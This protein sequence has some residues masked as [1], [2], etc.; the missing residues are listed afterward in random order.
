MRILL[1]TSEWPVG[2]ETYAGNFVKRQAK[3]LRR[4]GLDVE[5]FHFHGGKNPLNYLQAWAR[6]RPLLDRRRFDLVHAHFGQSGLLALPR[7]LPLVV[8]FHGTDVLGATSSVSDSHLRYEK[9]LSRVSRFVAARADALIV[10]GDHMRPYLPNTK[11]ISVI[12][13]GIDLEIFR[14]LPKDVARAHLGLP[15]D[16]HLVLFVGDPMS[17]IKHGTL[18]QRAVEMVNASVP[19]RLLV[20]SGVAPEEIPM[21]INAA[22][23]IVLTSRH[24]G[25]PNVVLEALACNRPVVSVDVGNVAERIAGIDGCHLCP[26]DRPETVARALEDVLR[27]NPRINGRAT[28]SDADERF[29]VQKV[30]GVYNAVIG[31]RGDHPLPRS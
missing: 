23:V 29:T 6:A 20:A 30:I 13:C 1:I 22:D 8:T 4:A 3:F 11:P 5:V 26:D 19:S 21:Y 17:P 9:I 24:E 14:P 25:A 27:R 31:D 28:V 18:A 2:G 7:R 15:Q 16:E 12:P 10:V